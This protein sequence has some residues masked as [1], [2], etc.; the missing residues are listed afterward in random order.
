MG[1]HEKLRQLLLD[2]LLLGE[3]EF[4]FD[5]RRAEVETWDSL[6][7]VAMAVGIKETF[8]YHMTPEEEGA[9]TGVADLITLLR[10]KG[11]PFDDARG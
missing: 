11:I 6:A 3:N 5:L 7:G 8:G 1:A 9:V 4:R 10:S 2:I